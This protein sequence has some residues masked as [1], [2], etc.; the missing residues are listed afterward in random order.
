MPA[1]FVSRDPSS[2]ELTYIK[3]M[4]LLI[5]SCSLASVWFEVV[6]VA[7]KSKLR[8]GSLTKKEAAAI[9]SWW[10]NFLVTWFY[11]TKEIV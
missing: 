7:V 2:D 5:V 11:H 8:V 10:G 4:L 3:R 6:L 9:V 1:R